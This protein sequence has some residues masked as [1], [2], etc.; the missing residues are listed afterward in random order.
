MIFSLVIVIGRINS[1]LHSGTRHPFKQTIFSASER[2]YPVVAELLL[3]DRVQ[4]SESD[5]SFYSHKCLG[6]ENRVCCM[7]QD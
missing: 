2:F 7:Q 4:N 3:P 5:P 6:S 1:C